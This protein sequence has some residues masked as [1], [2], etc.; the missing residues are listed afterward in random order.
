M[1]AQKLWGLAT[2]DRRLQARANLML[3]IMKNSINE[4]MLLSAGNKNHP[5]NF[6]DNKVSGILWENKADHTTYFGNNI[7]FIQG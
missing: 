4:Y 5:A 1:Y 2:G 7:E 3:G 6:V